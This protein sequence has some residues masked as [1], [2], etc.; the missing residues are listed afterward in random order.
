[1]SQYPVQLWSDSNYS[2]LSISLDYGVYSDISKIGFYH[3]IAS[4]IKVAPFTIVDLY[5]DSFSGMSISI[6]GPAEIPYLGTYASGQYSGFNDIISSLVVTQIS[7]TLQQQIDCCSGSTPGYKCGTYTPGNAKC[8][9]AY[10][11]QC[12]NPA[13]VNSSFCRAWCLKNP[14]ACDAA[15]MAFC[16]SN[17]NDPYCTCINSVA[18]QKN[19]INPKCIDAKCVQTG[20]L[21]SSM[22][23]SPCPSVINC[24]I[25]A[26]LVNSGVQLNT[27]IPI[28]QNCGNTTV[29]SPVP[30]VVPPKP[31]TTTVNI[32]IP[33]TPSTGESPD[34]TILFIFIF[35]ILLFVILSG[36]AIYFDIFDIFTDDGF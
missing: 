16:K 22:L 14:G 27:S 34:Y 25:N 23:N 8:E 18:S 33:V 9:T 15:A 6:A 20:Y 30:I 1:M 24:E 26:T 10:A 29:V 13:N 32:D 4:S 5:S 28:Q 19:I 2:G 11:V 36:I 17:P 21:T 31:T 3:D 12:S 7:P 35:L